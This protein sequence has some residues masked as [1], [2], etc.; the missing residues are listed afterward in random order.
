[1][2]VMHYFLKGPEALSMLRVEMGFAKNLSEERRSPR[3]ENL[4]GVISS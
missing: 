2:L 1:M 4:W 3:S